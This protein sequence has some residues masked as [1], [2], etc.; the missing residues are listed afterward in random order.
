M[1]AWRVKKKKMDRSIVVIKNKS[2]QL[3]YKT[4]GILAAF[5]DF[6][7]NLYSTKDSQDHTID[8]FLERHSLLQPLTLEN[9][10]WMDKPIIE[11]VLKAIAKMKNK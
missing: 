10:Q 8:S 9:K 5:Q 1:L 3:V 7:A 6:Y 2:N 11:E 4:K